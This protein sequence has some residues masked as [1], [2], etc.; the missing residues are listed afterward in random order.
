MEEIVNLTQEDVNR[1]IHA[2]P[3]KPMRGKV[4]IT[5]NVDEADGEVILTNSSFSE[6]QFVMAAGETSQVKAGDIV[7][8]DL[9]KMMEYSPSDTDAYEKVGRIKLR[10]IEVEGTTYALINE[11]LIDAV[12]TG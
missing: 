2:F 1:L 9:E 11:N 7:L 5:V 12:I 8:L 3:V 4:I 10:P 6:E